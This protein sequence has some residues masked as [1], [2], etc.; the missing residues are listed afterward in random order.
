MSFS[1]YIVWIEMAA[2]IVT[3]ASC[4]PRMRTAGRPT[5]TPT[6][7]ATITPIRAAIGH[8]RLGPVIAM[9][10]DPRPIPSAII[11]DMMNAA[12]PL[13]DIWASEICP[14]YPVSTTTDSMTIA[15]TSAV[16]SAPANTVRRPA[17]SNANATTATT[18]TQTSACSA[19]RRGRGDSGSR[20]S[21]TAPRTGSDRP[22]R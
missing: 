20:R 14:V 13:N 8:G 9:R 21:S 6:I 7:T 3:T 22:R 10:F 16:W 15:N 11:L 4:T 17:F 19:M 2:A 18:V 1:R 12:M 5:T